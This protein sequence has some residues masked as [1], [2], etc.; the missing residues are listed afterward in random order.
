MKYVF[1]QGGE[2]VAQDST[3]FF[4]RYVS[5]LIAKR[6]QVSTDNTYVNKQINIDN[7]SDFIK[8]L[9]AYDTE[10]SDNK[11]KDLQSQI[12][13]LQQQLHKYSNNLT[14]QENQVDWFSSEDGIDYTR[15]FYDTQSNNQP[16]FTKQEPLTFQQLQQRQLMAES[17]GYDKAISK[18]GAMGAYQ[19]MPATWDAYKPSPTADPMNRQDAEQA[20]NHYMNDL[21]NEYD[22]NQ[23]KAVAA[24]NY[25]SGN[26]NKLIKKYGNNWEQ[27]LPEET[28][29]YLNKI[30]YNNIKT[31][32]STVDLT[33]V[34]KN[35]LN[36][37]NTVSNQ[38]PGLIVTSGNDSTHLKN[39]AHYDGEAI[40]IGANSSNPSAYLAFKESLP[41]LKQKYGVRYI[42]EGDHIHLSLSSKGK[43]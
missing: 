31:K 16:V 22:N 37:I 10:Q 43:L 1:Q 23:Q 34:N 36:V 11:T 4:N 19:F 7:E 3:D 41:T 5:N 20:Y 39:S 38:F 12:D 25:G 33:D 30:F 26:V 15:S 21:L 2:Q 35:L 24:Y 28:K 29:N 27:Y 42:D 8:N 32:N 40:D 17:G 14:E 9:K 6:Q 13:Y 18:K